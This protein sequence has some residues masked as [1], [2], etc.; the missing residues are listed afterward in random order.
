MELE[1]ERLGDHLGKPC[2]EREGRFLSFPGNDCVFSLYLLISRLYFV[3]VD[4]VEEREEGEVADYG[5]TVD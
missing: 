3:G 1:V 5:I 2:L 4:S